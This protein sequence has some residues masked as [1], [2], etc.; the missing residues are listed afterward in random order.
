MDSCLA[1]AGLAPGYSNSKKNVMCSLL[2][3]APILK[4]NGDFW[5]PHDVETLYLEGCKG[6]S[7]CTWSKTMR[8]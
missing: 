3:I 1:N 5:K 4:R 8:N 7:T 2:F 6:G